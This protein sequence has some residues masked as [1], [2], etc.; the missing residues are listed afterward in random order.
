MTRKIT[1]ENYKE[2]P[3]EKLIEA[4]WNYK[5]T[6]T[7][8]AKTLA[9]KLIN[10]IDSDGQIENIIVRQLDNDLYEVING[11]HRLKALQALGHEKVIVCDLEKV[12]IHKAKKIAI[13]TNEL[14]FKR[15][16]AQFAELIGT[17]LEEDNLT[18]L[19]EELPFSADEIDSY[20]KMLD[21]DWEDFQDKEK[22]ESEPSDDF[23]EIKLNLPDE[24][25][26]QLEEQIER[27]KKALYPEEKK[28]DK[29]S[30]VMPVEAMC[31]ALHQIPDEQIL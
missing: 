13:K 7:E 17:L 24:V 16:E 12:S 28:L 23:R 1:L 21:F 25:A 9:Q 3:I 11:N 29:V 10:N 19:A 6:D 14:K 2:L 8:Q 18:D 20:Q 31:Q 27:F 26:C 5:E 4:N 15:D 22:K 30:Y